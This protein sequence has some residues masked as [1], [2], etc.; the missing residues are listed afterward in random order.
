[1]RDLPREGARGAEGSGEGSA[2]WGRRMR[3]RCWPRLAAGCSQITQRPSVQSSDT[4]RTCPPR[5]PHPAG[6]MGE[7]THAVAVAVV[8]A[9]GHP[10]VDAEA[11]QR[12]AEIRD[13]VHVADPDLFAPDFDSDGAFTRDTHFAVVGESDMLVVHATV[14]DEG[15]VEK[16]EMVRGATVQDGNFVRDRTRC[17]RH[18]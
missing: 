15:L 16:P 9:S 11:E 14:V 12:E 17:R 13:V 3:L 8:P 18:I 4:G 2:V 5:C 6:R 1:M 7:T 10:S